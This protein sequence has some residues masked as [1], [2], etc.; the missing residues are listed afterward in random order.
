MEEFGK[1]Y[2]SPWYTNMKEGEIVLYET[3]E[4][5]G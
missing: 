4:L 3:K 1:T 5:N 2:F